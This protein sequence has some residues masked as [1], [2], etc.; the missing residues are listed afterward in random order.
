MN[1]IA[2]QLLIFSVLL[3]SAII[4]ADICL[5]QSTSEKLEFDV[6]KPLLKGGHQ[7]P[8]PKT[9]RPG[10]SSA[11]TSATENRVDEVRTIAVAVP[12]DSDDNSEPTAKSD[13]LQL[14]EKNET[15][16][17]ILNAT[18]RR[19]SLKA[20]IA[21]KAP[22][23]IYRVGDG[24][25]LDVRLLNS[26]GK[27]STLYTILPGGLLDYPLAG[28]PMNVGGLTP[29]EIS[30]LLRE[31]IKLYEKPEVIVSVRDF[32]SHR[33]I[34][35]GSVEKPG[36]KIL[37]REAIPLF[38]VLAEA[39]Q[40]PDAARAVILRSNKQILNI[41]LKDVSGDILVQNGDVIRVVGKTP[42]AEDTNQF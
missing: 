6:N 23:E 11:K 26:S 33:V 30:E 9:N 13:D 7:L 27:D 1:T 18:A 10:G 28:E 19:E 3:I 17:N 4:P 32:A 42:E 16:E 20:R 15:S 12:A 21:S 35:N 8:S 25:I 14:N 41:D 40:M 36:A 38:A 34:V 31:K 37:K 22:T 39:E 2:K 5:A 29:E 24:D